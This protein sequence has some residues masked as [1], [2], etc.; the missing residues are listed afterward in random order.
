MGWTFP[1][2]GPLAPGLAVNS[3][4]ARASVE[5]AL[6]SFA[7]R[8][9]ADSFDGYVAQAYALAVVLMAVTVVSVLL[10]ERI[11]VRRGGWF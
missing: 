7:R 5:S 4:R 1:A 9:L 10:V 8:G 2:W 11:R 6:A 3:T